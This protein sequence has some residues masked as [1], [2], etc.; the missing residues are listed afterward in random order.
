MDN[1]VEKL[2]R[3][4]VTAIAQARD[5]DFNR[6]VTVSEIYQQ[7][8]PYRAARSAVGF[9][10][11]ADYEYALLR[12]LAGEGNF[13]RLEPGEVRET[14]R[15]ELE[16]P[17]PNVGLFREFANCDVWITAPPKWVFEMVDEP[18]PVIPQIEEEDD[19][20]DI[21]ILLED[22]VEEQ[23]GPPPPAP[24]RPTAPPKPTTTS[25]IQHCV[26]CNGELPA[27]RLANFCPHC[28][29]DQSQR[30]CPGCG[31]ILEPSWRFC[32]NCGTQI[33]GYDSAA[34]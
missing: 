17:N 15:S 27:G 16:S 5:G 11:N 4:L 2:H 31:E 18:D 1:S 23:E 7:L 10:M 22:V 13:A 34:N 20:E 9:E 12:L 30:P 14:L 29:S 26:F 32:A 19:A 3:A 6:P 25:A 24:P 21:E 33:T 28:G 8:L